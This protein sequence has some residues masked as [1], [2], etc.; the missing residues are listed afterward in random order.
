MRTITLSKSTSLLLSAVLA[1]PVMLSSYSVAYAGSAAKELTYSFS[2]SSST[3]AGYAQ[4]S[5]TLKA[6]AANTYKLYWA[7]DNKALDG[8]Y[9]ID[10][11]KLKA[12]ESKSVTM[13]YHTAIPAGAT[14]VIAVTDSL[15]TADAYTVYDIPQNKQ[16]SAVSGR[17]LY[18]FSTFSDVHIDRGNNVWYVNAENNFKKGLAY[19]VNNNADYLVISG[20]CVTNDSGPDKEWDA[21]EK[22]LSKS[23]FVNPVWE[24]DGNHDMRQGVSSG[25]KSFIKGSGTDG[26]NS[27]K[28]YFYRTDDLTGDL[29]I[30]MALELSSKP[31]TVDEFSDEQ[32]AWVTDLIQRN[33]ENVNIFLIEHSPIKGFGAGDRM[34]NPYYSGMLSQSYESTQ[35]FKALMEQYPKVVFLS[36]HTHEDFVM[37]YNYSNENGTAAHMIHTPSLAGSTMP[38]STDD[39][40]ERNDGKGF[41]SQAYFTEVYENEIVFYGVNI[42]EELK[43]P[44][45][46][47][48][49]EGYRTSSSPV[50][51]AVSP[52]PPKNKDV[53]L[54][55]ELEKVANILSEYYNLASYDRYQALKKQYYKYKNATIVDERVLDEFEDLIADL[56]IHAGTISVFP[57]KDTYYFINNN[58]WSKVYAYAWDG[59][60]KND[61]WPGVEMTKIGTSPDKKDIYKIEFGSERYANII[62]N[63]GSNEKQTVDL[64]LHSFQYDAFKIAGTDNGKYTVSNFALDDIDNTHYAL[65]YYVSG[66]HD[67][68]GI[69]TFL[70]SDGNGNYS[71]TY[72]P[73]N[74]GDISFSVYDNFEGKYY[75]LSASESFVFANGSEHEYT[76]EKLSSRGKSITVKTLTTSDALKIV[77]NPETKKITVNCK[78][79]A[80]PKELENTSTLSEQSIVQGSSVTLY[81]SAEGG[82][83]PYQYAYVV[84]APSGKWTV[85]KGYSRAESHTW[86][87]ASVGTYTIQFKV[88]DAS[89]TVKIKELSLNVRAALVNESTISAASI[90]KGKSV[91]LYGKAADGTAPY[92]F[93]YVVKAPSGKWTVLKGYSTA[94]SHT[95]TPASVGTYTIQFKVK[96]AS[97]TVKIKELSLN[98]TA[99]LSN[100]STISAA[101]IAKG[102]SVTLYGKASG[103]TAPYQFA[104]VVKAPSGKWTVLKGYST[105]E[106][107]TWTPASVGTYT[108]QIKAKDADGTV[109]IKELALTVKG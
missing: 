47:Y 70:K 37:G 64:S 31:N 7:D 40:L 8:Y 34:S 23:D 105:A 9:P 43:Y 6:D 96:D 32:L 30:F 67:W 92:Q 21:Y 53:D 100:E 94:E 80:E 42:L 29:F 68:S 89:G 1:I 61:D 58:S 49:M 4:G 10:E 107:H 97:G 77:F 35:K 44:K 17:L 26:S 48:I 84:K 28:P 41:N 103:G 15:Y 86:T 71:T 19:S 75:G 39:G 36:G 24:S 108:V 81:G 82:T 90:A 11:L 18:T 66:E 76:L 20:D 22:V 56:E 13:G 101:S 57:L 102:K 38:N 25:L 79:A 88:K 60:K 99:G 51:P 33:Y 93:A 85:L 52:L 5:I 65:L 87:P 78:P 16:L 54:T 27:G 45:Y 14:K 74:A 62:F 2:G 109:K 73:V 98:V 95:W 3:Q 12:G 59:S 72:I 69:D 55:P 83:A 63:C 50:C 46:T 91:T 104:Y 106:S